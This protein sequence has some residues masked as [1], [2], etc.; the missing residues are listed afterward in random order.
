M[1]RPG[2]TTFAPVSALPPVLFLRGDFA[3]RTLPPSVDLGSVPLLWV[4]VVFGAVS[5][6]RVAVVAPFSATFLQPRAVPSSPAGRSA[7]HFVRR[8]FFLV[9]VLFRLVCRLRAFTGVPLVRAVEPR[10][11]E[12]ALM[13]MCAWRKLS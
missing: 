6:F 8:V 9:L 2:Q 13:L 4:V 3:V 5:L 11:L 10:G 12:V 1:F 7:P